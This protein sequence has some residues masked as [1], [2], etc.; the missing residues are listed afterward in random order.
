MSLSRCFKYVNP[1]LSLGNQVFSNNGNNVSIGRILTSI[2]QHQLLK[3]DQIN[4]LN[5]R[6]FAR[7]NTVKRRLT[8]KFTWWPKKTTRINH[9]RML[10]AENQEFLQEVY[11]EQYTSPLNNIEI[12]KKVWTPDSKR[13]GLIARK[14]GV[15]PL[16]LKTGERVSCTLLQ[17][18]DNHVIN[19]QNVE[20]T[21]KNVIFQNRWYT[22]NYAT[23]VVGSESGDV[24]R[25]TKEYCSL[26]DKAG[27]PPKQKITKMVI[28][29]DAMLPPGTPLSV[30]HFKIGQYVDVFGKTID[31][32][33]QGVVTRWG[34]KGDGS[35]HH[36]AT[37]A[38]RRPGTIGQ[39][40][41]AGGPM[42]GRKMPGHMG[43]ERKTFRSMQV[44][45]I[46]TKHN[47]M[48]VKGQ[49]VPGLINAWVYVFDAIC[50]GRRFEAGDQPPF[51][52]YI[53]SENEQV[54]EE[55]N[56]PDVHLME[57]ETI[58]YPKVEE[59]K[60]RTG[61]KLAKVRKGK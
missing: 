32:N 49:G 1:N 15:L 11:K 20:E 48:W 18:N 50:K 41:K 19:C 14:I 56:H 27:V 28:T 8:H 38:H 45:R 61:A 10:S 43:D 31:R 35:K 52:T 16:W 36:G 24:T 59:S 9:N 6:R 33:F 51:P 39:S 47:I 30:Q 53:P 57:S 22:H 4:E 17:F 42:K 46:N 58:I 40:R 2:N 3:S 29:E 55:L 25:Y 5:Q 23:I 44:L 37:K 34:F 54:P 7:F 60:R 13:T 21:K 12:E 26:F